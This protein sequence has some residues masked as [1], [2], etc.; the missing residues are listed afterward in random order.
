MTTYNPFATAMMADTS[1]INLVESANGAQSLDCSGEALTDLFFGAAR[2]LDQNPFYQLLDRAWSS[3]RL[4]TLRILAHLRDVRGGK[5][6]RQLGRWGLEW[7]AQR[8]PRDLVH[9]LRHYVAT[10]GRWDDLVRLADY[11]EIAGNVYELVASQLRQ[12][13]ESLDAGQ[14]ASFCAK[15]TPLEGRH[16]LNSDNVFSR[17]VARTMG[18]S[19]RRFRR[20]LVRLRSHLAARTGRLSE[21][22]DYSSVPSVA[23]NRHGRRGGRFERRDGKRFQEW[24]D[25]L[26][27]GRATVNVG[28]LYPYQ[29]VEKYFDQG[30]ELD[31]LVEAQWRALCDRLGPE[32]LL[33]EESDRLGTMLPLID[34]SQPMFYQQDWHDPRPVAVAVSLGLLLARANPNPSFREMVLTFSET[35][36][37]HRVTGS[38]HEQVT[39]ISQDDSGERANLQAA[40]QLVLDR[41]Q[42]YRL[43]PSEMPSTLVVFSRLEFAD[44]GREMTNYGALRSAYEKAGY[45]VPEVVFWSVSGRTGDCPVAS[46]QL[47][48][49]LVSGYS[50]ETFRDLLTQERL[51]P[52]RVMTRAVSRP[53]YVV[54]SPA[55]P[56]TVLRPFTFREEAIDRVIRDYR[57]GRRSDGGVRPCLSS[58]RPLYPTPLEEDGHETEIDRVVAGVVSNVLDEDQYLDQENNVLDGQQESNFLEVQNLLEGQQENDFLEVHNLLE[59]QQENNLLE[60]QELD[61][62]DQELDD[63]EIQDQEVDD[64]DHDQD[65]VKDEEQ[66]VDDQEIQDQEV[67]DQEVDDQDLVKD[68]D[69]EVDEGHDWLI[70]DDT[71]DRS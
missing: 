2:G 36:R 55:P 15:W 1:S 19:R 46:S 18:I 57:A 68:E 27:G 13:L 9:N 44:V 32:R 53:E 6:E 17:R 5:G 66:E 42:E 69:Q 64:Q 45:P 24:K 37:F 21:A 39:A 3:D 25:L 41:A 34:I 33:P 14:P 67:D 51:T 28:T 56:N 43:Q 26:E 70:I 4:A 35:A 23:I 7:L 65:L 40:L 47:G 10:F 12:D 38:L 29:A 8:S 59:G 63:Q 71:Q 54:I 30:E 48:T 16:R 22:T 52:F 31:P 20:T 50:L 60:D 11:P 61:D 62:Q 49:A 58:I